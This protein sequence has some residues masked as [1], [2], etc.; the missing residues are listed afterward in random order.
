MITVQIDG[1]N[2]LQKIVQKYPAVS[3]KYVNAAINKSLVRIMGAEK[4]TAP[5]GVSGILRDNW[6][7]N[8][9]RFTGTLV[10]L[11]PYAADVEYGTAPHM[12]NITELTPWAAKKGIPVWAVAMSIKKYGTKPNPFF[13][14]AVDSVTDSIEGDFQD[15]IDSCLSELTGLDDTL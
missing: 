15:A 5:F 12:P 10:S 1:M 4:Q 11:A 14:K 3:E 6:Q 9:G 2:R 8:M 7:V 13:Q